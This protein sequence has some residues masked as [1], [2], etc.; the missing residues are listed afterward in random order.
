[1]QM[2]ASLLP[3]VALLSTGALAKDTDAALAV[4]PP[5]QI[6]QV[7]SLCTICEMKLGDAPIKLVSQELVLRFSVYSRLE[8]VGGQSC[9]KVG[10]YFRDPTLY[11]PFYR[12]LGTR[13]GRKEYVFFHEVIIDGVASY[14]PLEGRVRIDIDKMTGLPDA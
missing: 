13:E 6:E 12:L 5:A 9:R 2:K 3:L 7:P 10:I 14:D 8:L 4:A 11:R 1:M